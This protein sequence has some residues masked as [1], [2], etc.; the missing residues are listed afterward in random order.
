MT[1][2]DQQRA[3]EEGAQ[4][5]PLARSYSIIARQVLVKEISRSL[6]P[7]PVGQLI[8]MVLAMAYFA[9]L[10]GLTLFLGQRP[11]GITFLA[12]ALVFALSFGVA[13][14]VVEDFRGSIISILNASKAEGGKGLEHAEVENQQNISRGCKNAEHNFGG[15]R[16]SR[17]S[18]SMGGLPSF[19]RL[20]KFILGPS[21][22]LNI[23][24]LHNEL[25]RD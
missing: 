25:N 18:D 3:L 2:I 13:L 5:N 21:P 7:T 15:T 23:E 20:G 24:M 17:K 12:I 4:R 19:P 11:A 8:L 22:L 14:G 10:G 16:L 1:G 9:G 6:V